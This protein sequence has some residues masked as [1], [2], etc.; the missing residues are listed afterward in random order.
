MKTLPGD[1][2]FDDLCALH[3][4][5][6]GIRAGFSQSMA[7]TSASADNQSQNEDHGLT[8]VLRAIE[9]RRMSTEQ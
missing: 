2:L 1:L 6:G 4:V 7:N 3:A 9:E 5:S 8:A